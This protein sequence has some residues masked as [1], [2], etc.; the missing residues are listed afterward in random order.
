[1]QPIRIKLGVLNE[2]MAQM[3]ETLGPDAEIE[4]R[5]EADGLHFHAVGVWRQLNRDAPNR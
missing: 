1:M 3:G 2:L 5:I 4:V